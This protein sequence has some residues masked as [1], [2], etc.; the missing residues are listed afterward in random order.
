MT[1]IGIDTHKATL[2]ALGTP[3]FVVFDLA[4]G[5]RRVIELRC[6]GPITQ[7]SSISAVTCGPEQLQG[8]PFFRPSAAPSV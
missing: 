3:L 5:S 4:D 7:G 1:A 8:L 6:M 2:A